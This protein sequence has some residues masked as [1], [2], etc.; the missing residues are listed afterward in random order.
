LSKLKTQ[1]SM[2]NEKSFVYKAASTQVTEEFLGLF[3]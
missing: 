2:I 1:A 3:T